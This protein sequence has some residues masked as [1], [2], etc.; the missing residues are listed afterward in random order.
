MTTEKNVGSK[1]TPPQRIRLELIFSQALEEDFRSEFTALNIGKK[2][3]KFESVMGAGCSNPCLGDSV[4]PELNM[5][6]K[7]IFCC[8]KVAQEIHN[9][10]NCLLYESRN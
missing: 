7:N 3:T 1:K 10:G 8:K 6:K 9:R 4:W 2:Y 5:S